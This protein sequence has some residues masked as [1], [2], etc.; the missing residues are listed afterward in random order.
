MFVAIVVDSLH[1]L[2]DGRAVL[3]NFDLAAHI[4]DEMA[5]Q[6]RVG[7][8]G[9]AA[10]EII[11]AKPYGVKVDVFAAGVTLYLTLSSTQPFAAPGVSTVMLL[12][13]KCKPK[14]PSKLFGDVSGGL[15]K[16]QTH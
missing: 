4:D 1:I 15:R 9:Y 12:T 8:P 5:M 2:E 14:F 3:T 13:S 7:T 11:D 6:S 10:P 16:Q